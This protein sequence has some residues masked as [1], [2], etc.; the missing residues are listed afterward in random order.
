MDCSFSTGFSASSETRKVKTC[1]I[2][3]IFQFPSPPSWLLC[4]RFSVWFYPL[5]WVEHRDS[6][7]YKFASDETPEMAGM[8]Q[9]CRQLYSQSND[10]FS[11]RLPFSVKLLMTVLLHK[12]PGDVWRTSSSFRVTGGFGYEFLINHIKARLWYVIDWAMQQWPFQSRGKTGVFLFQ[13]SDYIGLPIPHQFLELSVFPV[14]QPLF[15]LQWADVL[16]EPV[17][18]CRRRLGRILK[19]L[20]E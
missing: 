6:Y 9:S 14:I 17:V 20:L 3:Y 4:R 1:S 12:M 18:V 10:R 11:K 7:R 2:P 5:L 15:N 19:W 8:I 13:D 16:L